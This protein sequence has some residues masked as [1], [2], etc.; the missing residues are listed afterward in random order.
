MVEKLGSLSLDAVR[1]NAVAFGLLKVLIA[2]RELVRGKTSTGR[3]ASSL[4]RRRSRRPP[5]PP[6]L[7]NR[8]Y[9]GSIC[10]FLFFSISLFFF[11]CWSHHGAFAEF[12]R[13]VHGVITEQ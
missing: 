5:S 10:F 9:T 8:G 11:F 12:I 2:Q 1:P 3:P 7:N 13:S 4:V 6:G